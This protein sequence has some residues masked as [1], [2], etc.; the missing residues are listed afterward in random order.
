MKYINSLNHLDFNFIGKIFGKKTI[1]LKDQILILN[2]EK[3]STE[4]VSLS[5]VKRFAYIEKGIFGA[6]LFIHNN[7]ALEEYKFLSQTNSTAFLESINKQI[8]HSLQ[9]YVISLVKEFN[10]RVLS[11][12]PRDSKLDSIKL[13]ADELAIFYKND[14]MLWNYFSDPK[15]FNEVE[16]IYGLCPIKQETLGAYHERIN[17]EQ[18]KTFFD[19]VESNPL[20]DEQ[21]LGVLRS[22]DKNMVLAAAGT[23]KTSVMVAKALDLIDR[24]LA[25]PSEILV[26]AYNKSAAEELRKRLA[27]KAEKSGIVLTETPQISTFHALGRK[28]LGDSN[29]STYMNV[30]TEDSLKLDAWVTEWLIGYLIKDPKRVVDFIS[31]FPEPVNPFDFNNQEE[32]ERYI[33]DNELRTLQGELVKGYQELIIAN[34]L[35]IH[36][37]PYEYEARYISK[38][39]IDVGF[40]YQPDFHISNSNIYI[41]HF[42]ID[43]R[44]NTRPDINKQA[45]NNSIDSKR[46]LHKELGTVLVETFH[47]DW[48]EDALEERLEERL[49][50]VGVIA[51][52]NSVGSASKELLSKLKEGNQIATW[53][54]MLVKALQATRFERLNEKSIFDRLEKANISQAKKKTRIINDLHKAY[55]EE[56]AATNSI[57]FDDMIIRAIAVVNSGQ[58]KPH[59][60]YILVDE[61]QDIS[62]SRMEFV[63]SIIQRG[64]DPSL[65]VVG[66]DWQSIY[67]F[68]GGKLELTTRF[69]ELVGSHTL[70]MLQKT[71]R[72][73]NSIADTAGTFIMENPEQYRKNIKTHEVA[74]ESQV[75]LLDDRAGEEDGVY[76]RVAEVVSK[77][78]ANDPEGSIAIMARY[79]YL[80]KNSRDF[81]GKE[82]SKG[83]H[84]WSF[85][86]SKGLEADYCILIGFFQ[87]KSG[88]PNSNREDAIPE[89]LLPTLDSFPHSEE[90]RLLYVGIT[91]CKKK[92]YIIAS[93]TAPSE[94][95]LELLAP[96][97]NIN[98]LS[99]SFQ[100]RHR[101]V[102]KCPNC[103]NGYLRLIKGPY[104]SFYGCSS[105]KGCI[106]GKARVCEKCE[107]P[108]IDREN[109]SLCNNKDCGNSIKI[110]NKCGRP[111]RMREGKFGKFWGCSGYGIKDDQCTNT[112]KI[113]Y[114]VK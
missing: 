30:F 101:N 56:L 79:N 2:T 99:E 19:N 38:R 39:R 10:T 113:G 34:W 58:Y 65:T 89:A 54:K 41:E 78:R 7:Q 90:R 93:S 23:G 31:L 68:S 51:D 29:I 100:E 107:A 114:G 60:R 67:R 91:R 13:V 110:C 6:T 86:K 4:L 103:I 36:K 45:Y 64:P 111:M 57:D 9:P 50:A 83:I 92:S 12:Y 43:R 77:I 46:K 70:T 49:A 62:A 37:I 108:S 24:G 104:G 95:V 22:N 71:F 82:K 26:L 40:D 97:Y 106:V 48:T 53:S 72:Y 28:I 16:K 55:V 76:L 74:H 80:L 66:D 25:L 14:K 18:R 52:K 69:N 3:G 15:I 33:R 8:A 98:I 61:F 73:N 96:K 47:Y 109:E 75:Y 5:Q 87:G 112:T 11:N 102:F 88:F 94:F 20:T 32:Y 21:R 17:L 84:F 1:T 35:A 81:L 59:W 85:H 63:N 27:D 44:G 105:G 42:G